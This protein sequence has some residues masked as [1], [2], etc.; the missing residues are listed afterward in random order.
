[1]IQATLRLAASRTS[2][3]QEGFVLNRIGTHSIRAAGAMAL[4]LNGVEPLT[5]RKLGRWR[6][7]TWLTYLHSQIAKLTT[8]MA[9]HDL[10]NCF[11]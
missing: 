6:S 1:M 10:A 8:G 4:F 11:P 3:W 2:L 9:C 7:E 5:I